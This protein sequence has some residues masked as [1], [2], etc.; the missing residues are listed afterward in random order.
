MITSRAV[1]ATTYGRYPI[2][3]EHPRENKSDE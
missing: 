2:N 1:A 3:A